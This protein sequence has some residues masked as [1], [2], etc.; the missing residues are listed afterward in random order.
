MLKKILVMFPL[1]SHIH[2]AHTFIYIM[3]PALNLLFPP[4]VRQNFGS[5]VPY[6]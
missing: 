6:P 2:H 3:L 5:L 1:P 4:C